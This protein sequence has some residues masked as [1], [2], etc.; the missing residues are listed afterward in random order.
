MINPVTGI[1]ETKS[2]V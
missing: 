1:E 2:L